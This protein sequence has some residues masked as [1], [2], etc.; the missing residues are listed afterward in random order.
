MSTITRREQSLL[1]LAEMQI[2]SQVKWGTSIS[3]ELKQFQKH[4]KKGVPN[5]MFCQHKGNSKTA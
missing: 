3:D 1:L 5:G 2:T 4:N